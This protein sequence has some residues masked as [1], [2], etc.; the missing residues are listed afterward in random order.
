MALHICDLIGLNSISGASILEE[1]KW[2]LKGATDM[3]EPR[4]KS[5]FP[6]FI[7]N[8]ISLHSVCSATF[9]TVNLLMVHHWSASHAL[10]VKF[11]PGEKQGVSVMKAHSD[12][13]TGSFH[14][15]EDGLWEMH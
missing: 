1:R 2:R 12:S 10:L 5:R 6:C 8:L 9:F 3:A 15:A 4:L 7:F 11:T 14:S 13:K